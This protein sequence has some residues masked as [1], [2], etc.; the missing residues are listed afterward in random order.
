MTLIYNESSQHFIMD[1]QNLIPHKTSRGDPIFSELD[2]E[3]AT[4]YYTRSRARPKRIKI[5]RWVDR[6]LFLVGVTIWA[7]EG[8]RTRPY[9]L[10][11]TNSSE[12]IAKAFVQLLQQLR[13]SSYVTLRVHAPKEGYETYRRYWRKTLGTYRVEISP[14][15]PNQAACGFAPSSRNAYSRSWSGLVSNSGT[16]FSN[17][18]TVFKLKSSACM[19][20]FKSLG[21]SGNETGA[22]GSG[23]RE[24]GAAM[25]FCRPFWK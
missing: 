11:F 9:E 23:L 18:G 2:A 1:L 8:T 6:E 24:N 17:P 14:G 10:E 25:V 5:R 7:C 3:F 21:A 15:P 19:L 22:R 12:T 16:F 13:L 20:F 4:I